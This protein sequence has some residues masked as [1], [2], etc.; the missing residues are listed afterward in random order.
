MPSLHPGDG[1]SLGRRR[2]G[3]HTPPAPQAG[4]AEDSLWGWGAEAMTWLEGWLVGGIQHT[5][6]AR[7]APMPPGAERKILKAI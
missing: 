1:S 4:A 5:P 3:D 2:A 7:T 6:D